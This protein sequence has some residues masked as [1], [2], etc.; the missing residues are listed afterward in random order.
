MELSNGLLCSTTSFFPCAGL[1]TMYAFGFC[2]SKNACVLHNL[3]QLKF[4]SGGCARP[5]TCLV[6][7]HV[8]FLLACSDAGLGTYC[9]EVIR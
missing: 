9:P 5:V 6:C 1:K 7:N 3:S 4:I 8:H 2:G